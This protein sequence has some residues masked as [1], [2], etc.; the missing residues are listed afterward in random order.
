M[1]QYSNFSI[2]WDADN[3]YG[4]IHDNQDNYLGYIHYFRNNTT[5]SYKVKLQSG[6]KTRLESRDAALDWIDAQIS[7]ATTILYRCGCDYESCEYCD[8]NDHYDI[9]NCT[10]LS[11]VCHYRVAIP[12]A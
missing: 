11:Q 6:A 8:W 2:S 4:E 3:L 5:T 12:I 9:P 1:S 7:L 10:N